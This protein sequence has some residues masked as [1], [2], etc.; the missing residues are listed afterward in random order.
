MNRIIITGISDIAADNVFIFV[1]FV[2]KIRLNKEMM[3]QQCVIQ[4]FVFHFHFEI[5]LHKK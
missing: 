1:I 3:L 5:L 2:R 4:S